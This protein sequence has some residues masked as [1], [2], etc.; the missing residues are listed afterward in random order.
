ML[1]LFGLKAGGSGGGVL[2]TEPV[3]VRVIETLRNLP[4][5]LCED[6]CHALCL[7]LNLQCLL[8]VAI[9]LACCIHPGANLQGCL[10]DQME[11]SGSKAG[12]A[13]LHHVC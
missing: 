13:V 1:L 9:W 6:N 5:G 7:R 11:H 12:L 3:S 8:L 4:V 10:N 2:L